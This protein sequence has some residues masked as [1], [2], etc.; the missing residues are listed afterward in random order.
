M[1]MISTNVDSS[2]SFNFTVTR[3]IGFSW[4]GESASVQNAVAFVTVYSQYGNP[5]FTTGN[6]RPSQNTVTEVYTGSGTFYMKVDISG[7]VPNSNYLWDY[8]VYDQ[9]YGP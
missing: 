9:L 3:K 5:L 4:W 6:I 1:G 7:M 2:T 8:E